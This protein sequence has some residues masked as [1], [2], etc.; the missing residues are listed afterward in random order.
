MK[1]IFIK[2]EDIELYKEE[3]KKGSPKV[4]ERDDVGGFESV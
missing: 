3:E 1:R 2:L 4:E